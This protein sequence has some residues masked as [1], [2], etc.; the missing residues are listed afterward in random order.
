MKPLAFTPLVA[1]GSVIDPGTVV[2]PSFDVIR[3]TGPTA[4]FRVMATL[5]MSLL[6]VVVFA[7]DP[8]R[9]LENAAS[10]PANWL[11]HGGTYLEQRHSPLNAINDGNVSKLRLAW[12]H[13]LDTSRGQE[14]TPLVVDG[15]LYTSTAWSKVVAVDAATGKLRWNFDPQVPGDTGPKACCDVVNRG[16]AYHDGRIF[17]GTLDGRLIALDAK[18][19]RV[20]WT[21]VTVDPKSDYTITGAPRIVKGNVVIGNGGAELGVRGF[22]TAYD[23]RTGRQVWRFYTVPGDPQ[24][25]EDGAASDDALRNIARPTWFGDRYWRDGAGGTVWDAIVY[26]AELDQLYIGVGNGSP[27]NHRI[28]SEGR[29]DNLFLS[30]IVALNPDT[31]RYLWHYQE[32][33]ADTWD[34]TATQQMTLA[35][36]TIDGESRKVILHAP[37]SGFFYVIDRR[38]GKLLSA[39]KFAPVNWATH[40]DLATGR[41]V[42]APNARFANGPFFA[43]SG[44]SGAHNWQ[45]MAFSP[46]TGLVYLPAQMIPF[47]YIEDSKYRYTR[48]LWNLGVDMMAVPLPSTDADRK[49]MTE[50]LQGWLLAWDPVAGKEVWRHQYKGPWNGGVLSTA[51]DL[52]FQGDADG[53]FSAFTARD[54]HKLWGF[55]AQTAI[56]AAPISYSVRGKQFVA[57]LAGNGGGVPLA[58]PAFGGPKPSPNGR[59]LA[60]A[61]DGT[62]TLPK[63]EP[64]V[65]PPNPVVGNWSPDDV[66]NGARSYARLCAGCHGMGTLSAGVLPDLR[67]SGALTDASTWRAIVID[68]ALTPRGMVSFRAHLTDA[69]TENLRGYLSSEARKIAEK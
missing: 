29:G 58:L 35:E 30:S 49:A 34:F 50:L 46:R 61:L 19:G 2:R 51:G 67:R 5:I 28:R 62:A 33:P 48:G 27:W 42:E 14:A 39:E 13:D 40:V 1:V 7:K 57:V 63:F 15:T 36:L 45:A 66:A 25:G 8:P 38:G 68:G 24:R 44:A 52:V 22:V 59:I 41:P 26:D 31:G 37:K 3:V 65:P 20:K 12:F 64:Y 55:D 54:G 43:T 69:E 53:R 23:T 9:R 21:V 10:E 16:V 56:I 6:S 4:R 32:T 11:T 60:F 18:S 47:L 17:V